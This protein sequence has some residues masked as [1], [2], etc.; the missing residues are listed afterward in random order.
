MMTRR[1]AL[2]T[3]LVVAICWCTLGSSTLG[4]S[5]GSDRNH[6]GTGKGQRTLE[7]FVGSASQPPTEEAIVAFE[8]KMGVT[9]EAHFGGSG[10]MLSQMKLSGRGDIYFPGSSDYME[11]AKDEGLVDA[12]TEK[13]VVY[14]VPAINVQAG[15][16]KNIQ[17]VEDLARPGIKVGMARP[18]TVCVGLYG[19]EALEA[20]GV[21]ANVKPNIVTHAPSC[22]KAANLV[23]L[24]TVDAVL[25]WRVFQF[26]DPERIET[27]YYPKEKVTRIG[28]IPVAV[29]K[30]AKN[31][32]LAEAFIDF[33]VSEE[34]QTHFR[35]WK[36]LTSVKEAR[37]F[38]TANT[39]VGGTWV[40]PTAWTQ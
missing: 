4:C 33:L 29:A 3:L 31:R 10:A 5:R 14:L 40:I 9:V 2:S 12:A 32:T 20:M 28:Y 35:K 23:A 19:V 7:I 26:W 17:S 25:G 36:Y 18:D 15:N 37:E 6:D 34:G 39:P 13:R 38:A 16:P 1:G 24:Q 8:K 22:S 11:R 21:S 27:I 30:D